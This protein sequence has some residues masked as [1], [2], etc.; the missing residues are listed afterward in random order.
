VPVSGEV[1]ADVTHFNFQHR[2]FSSPGAKFKLHGRERRP[3]FSVDVGRNEGVIELV[4]LCREF[5]IDPDSLDGRL[6]KL[7]IEGLRFVP[8]IKPGDTI[9]SELLTGEASWNA[10]AKYVRIAQERLQIQLLSWLSGREVLLTDPREITLYIGQLENR[11]KLKEAFQSAARELGFGTNTDKAVRQLDLLT[12]ELSY[13]EALRDRCAALQRLERRI[14]ELI[15]TYSSDRAAKNEIQR[16]WQLVKQGVGEFEATF[17]ELD[18]Q[19]G[20]VIAALKGLDRQV[21][22]IRKVRDDLHE[23]FKEWAPHID[24]QERWPIRRAPE[25]DKAMA[26]LHRFVAARFAT[27]RSL[28]EMTR[29]GK[30]VPTPRKISRG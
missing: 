9:P 11:E 23:R 14:A 30:D 2:V 3:V 10:Q 21:T 26:S 6:I 19:T 27:G 12:R 24:N 25:T 17:D 28:L 7:A 20:E 13:I 4:S 1:P 18:A 29:G 22:Y 8:D 5:G 15:H 16:I